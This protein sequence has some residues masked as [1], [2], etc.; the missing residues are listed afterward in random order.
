MNIWKMIEIA[1]AKSL[2]SEY[3]Q[4]ELKRVGIGGNQY[5][6]DY[7]LFVHKIMLKTNIT[8]YFIV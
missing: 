6:I 8:S 2:D 4:L 3:S 7:V 1:T 5:L